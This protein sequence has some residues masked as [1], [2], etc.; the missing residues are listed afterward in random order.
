MRD[1]K[2]EEIPTDFTCEKCGGKMVVKWGRNGNFLACASYPECKSTKEVARNLDGTF[3]I[4]PEPTTDEKCETC[5][6]GMLV[7]RGKFGSF[8]A[9]S[10]YPDCKT[11][12]PISLGVKCPREGCG[13]QIAEKRSRRGKSFF[14][15]VNWKS[16]GCDFV[17][18]DRPIPQP[19]PVCNA[20]FVVKKETKRGT[21]LRCLECDWKQGAEETEGGENAA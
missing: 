7:K 10:R 1:V 21:T 3:E 6:A 9:C 4:V 14:G 13:G 17:V 20:K 19:C 16:K 2:R 15:C 8:L 11:T 18:W 12:K 5:G